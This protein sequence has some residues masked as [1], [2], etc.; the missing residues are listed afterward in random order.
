MYKKKERLSHEKKRFVLVCILFFFALIGLYAQ[1]K[2]ALVIGNA[3]YTAATP[4]RNPVNDANDME[5]TLKSLGWTVEKVLNGSLASMEDSVIRLRNRLSVSHDSYGFFFYAGHGVQS[6]GENYLIPVDA[7]IPSENYLRQRAVS[8]QT[9]LAELNDAGNALNV[10]VLDACRDNPFSWARSGN[11]GLTLVSNQPADSIIVYATSAGSTAA[12]GEG[13]NGLFTAHFLNNLK[14]P[15]VEVS[16]VF[17]R[18]MGDV[19]RASGNK[20][21][22]AVY[23]QFPGIAYLGSKPGNNTPAPQPAP[24]GDA[25]AYYNL[26]KGHYDKREYDQAVQAFSEA[27]RLNSQYVDAFVYRGLAY[28]NKGNYDQEIKD[29]SEAIRL[30]PKY[31]LAYYNR[32]LA[33]YN[34]KD[35]DQAVKDY[36]EAIWLDPKYALAYNNRGLAYY[37]KWNYDQAIADYN[38]AIRLDPKYAYAYNN[39]GLAYESKKNYDQAIKDYGEA[40]RFN[41]Q[42]A[43]AY[44]NRGIAYYYKKEYDQAIKDYGEAIRLD[45]K[46]V[47][48]YYNRGLAYYYKKEYDQAIKD[49]AEAIRLNP[50]Y[51]NAYNNRGNAYYSKK[52]YDLAIRD[53]TEAIRLNPQYVLA[54]RNRGLAY[55]YKGNYDQ[56]IKDCSEAIRLDPKYADAYN[57]RGL[58]Y[59]RKKDYER[60]IAD[61]DAALRFDQSHP[62]AR[63]NKQ[64][65]VNA[66]GW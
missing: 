31:A 26:G 15:G 51:A 44:Y 47:N 19:A 24:S 16:E 59:Y 50:Q 5:A 17:R 11:R 12:D 52:D 63:K 64:D 49:S 38:E 37:Y 60:A 7:N 2:Y 10:V 27:I 20:Q 22:P 8:M 36:T 32:G 55:Y 41:P 6:N 18:T 56:A 13:R 35:Y 46:Y 43:L 9:M 66:R 23:S 34:K 25:E 62:F 4:L 39:R 54:Y 14:S 29:H 1:Q 40:I 57:D 21:R 53:Y 65:A 45:P 33:Y 28:G 58:A 61:Y 48:A 30:N 3:A 42:Y